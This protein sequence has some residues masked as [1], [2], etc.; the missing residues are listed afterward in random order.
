M[1]HEFVKEQL[2]K[3]GYKNLDDEIIE[4]F[5]EKLQ[6]DG[7][8]PVI[9]TIPKRFYSKEVYSKNVSQKKSSHSTKTQ[10]NT[11]IE[12]R[13]DQRLKKINKN[14][15]FAVKSSKTVRNHHKASY[16]PKKNG[17]KGNEISEWSNKLQSIKNKGRE[18]DENIKKCKLA[19]TYSPDE[20]IDVPIY[21]GPTA[22]YKRDPYPV[23][24]KKK[25]GGFIRP[26]PI[27][28]TRKHIHPNGHKLTYKE[29]FPDYVPA[30]ERRRDEHRWK[31]RQK[32]IYS[33]PKY[34]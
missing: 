1:D 7:D 11:N 26:P 14:E 19:I 27:R 13:S 4:E 25:S 21:F 8:L 16:Y 5:L 28:G 30:P 34:H 10:T 24:W 32:F 23:V 22:D 18:L 3:L 6:E 15:E 20:P 17:S 12:K 31:L 29:R 2:E 33:D 9:P